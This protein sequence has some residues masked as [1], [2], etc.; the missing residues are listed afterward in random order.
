VTPRRPRSRSA[1]RALARRC[2]TKRSTSISA[3][4]LPPDELAAREHAV[5]RTLPR[6]ARH[7]ARRDHR[8]SRTGVGRTL[9]LG[10]SASATMMLLMKD[11]RE[12]LSDLSPRAALHAEIPCAVG[13]QRHGRRMRWYRSR[14]RARSPHVDLHHLREWFLLSSRKTQSHSAQH[15]IKRSRSVASSST[16]DVTRGHNNP[17]RSFARPGRK[18]AGP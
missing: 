1:S 6:N 12:Y 5:L 8:G 4:A 13:G 7:R 17:S 18:H 9:Q 14:E 3:P 16:A 2:A 10:C 15:L 11:P